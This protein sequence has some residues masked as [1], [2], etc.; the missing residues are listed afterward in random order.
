VIQVLVAQTD[1]PQGCLTS[2][3]HKGK[4]DALG[5]SMQ[6]NSVAIFFRERTQ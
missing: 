6:A 2:E 4:S 5:G 3:F 1:L